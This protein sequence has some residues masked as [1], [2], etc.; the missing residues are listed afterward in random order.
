M[1]VFN[2]SLFLTDILLRKIVVKNFYTFF[3]ISLQLSRKELYLI[4]RSDSLIVSPPNFTAML[5][6]QTIKPYFETLTSTDL[7]VLRGENTPDYLACYVGDYGMA[8]LEDA[9]KQIEDDGRTEGEYA[10]ERGGC[11]MDQET[12]FRE[13]KNSGATNHQLRDLL[14]LSDYSYL[15]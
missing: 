15:I 8:Y 10:I 11:V 9:N 5:T 13:F 14:E 4:M 1:E 6:A 3:Q 7:E 2:P 12:F